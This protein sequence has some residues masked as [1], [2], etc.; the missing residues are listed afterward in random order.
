MSDNRWV[1]GFRRRSVVE[2]IIEHFYPVD[3]VAD[4]A[5]AAMPTPSACWV[6]SPAEVAR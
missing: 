1:V 3:G 2:V 6:M 5:E 4:S